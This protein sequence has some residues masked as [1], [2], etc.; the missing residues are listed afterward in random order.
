MGRREEGIL[1]RKIYL[2]AA[3]VL[4]MSHVNEHFQILQRVVELFLMYRKVKR[5]ILNIAHCL[6]E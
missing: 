4:C 1:H 6:K 5:E 2:A 3:I